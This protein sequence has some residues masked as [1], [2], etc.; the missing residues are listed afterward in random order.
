MATE[1]ASHHRSDL[2]EIARRAMIERG[3]EPDF[4]PDANAQLQRLQGPAPAAGPGAR[5]LRDLLWCSID[6]DDSRDLDQLTVSESPP[7]GGIR[8]LVAVADVDVLVRKDD[9]IDAHARRNTTSVYTAAQ[10]FPMLPEQLST[11]WTSLNQDQ[12]RGA[13]VI[14]FEVGGDGSVG[15]SSVFLASVRSK[16]KLAYDAVS[17]W[18]DGKSEPPAAI[19]RVPGLAD[20]LRAQKAAAEKL[21]DRRFEEGALDLET[22]QP[23]AVFD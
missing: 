6:N 13:L 18:L 15:E 9:A 5:D 21:R 16:A 17:A 10:I 22:I 3:L 4:P 23:K 1:R 8:I 14:E 12:D 7:G 11:D 19:A 20:Q 2:I